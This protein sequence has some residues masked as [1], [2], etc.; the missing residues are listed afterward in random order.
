MLTTASDVARAL[1]VASSSTGAGVSASWSVDGKLHGALK[2]DVAS[3]CVEW[4]MNRFRAASYLGTPASRSVLL[5]GCTDCS[6]EAGD[7]GFD[8]GERLQAVHIIASLSQSQS[9]FPC[10]QSPKPCCPLGSP[11]F[12]PPRSAAYG[13]HTS[14]KT[15]SIH[16]RARKRLASMRHLRRP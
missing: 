13:H 10:K 4:C 15:P 5:V 12:W 1:Q 2:R 16:G 8:S 6:V 7:A 14:L 9:L 11:C 3:V